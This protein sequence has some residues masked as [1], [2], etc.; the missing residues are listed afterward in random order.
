VWS[1]PGAGTEIEFRIP[2]STVYAASS[3]RGSFQPFW[4]RRKNDDAQSS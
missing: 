4:K 3:S 1:E 2:G